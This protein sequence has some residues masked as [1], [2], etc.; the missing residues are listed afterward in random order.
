[1]E[2]GKL[3]TRN[4]RHFKASGA[5]VLDPWQHS[6]LAHPLTGNPIL[7][8]WRSQGDAARLPALHVAEGGVLVRWGPS[9][10][11]RSSDGGGEKQKTPSVRQ[12]HRGA[13]VTGAPARREQRA[14]HS[15]IP[16]GLLDIPRRP[17]GRQQTCLVAPQGRHAVGG[18]PYL[19]AAKMGIEPKQV[20]DRGLHGSI[21]QAKRLL[22]MGSSCSANDPC[23]T[24]QARLFIEFDHRRSTRSDATPTPDRG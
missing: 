12:G 4:A 18:P 22:V 23:Q 7:A 9:R 6:C 2:Q 3:M 21:I 19:R 17:L 16:V 13:L 1:M 8:R 5:L 14:I 20:L 10:R 15:M 11:A 24:G